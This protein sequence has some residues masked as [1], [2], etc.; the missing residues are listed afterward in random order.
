MD[1]HR[2]G[3]RGSHGRAAG[4]GGEGVGAG[5]GAE[6]GGCGDGRD[7]GRE[8]QAALGQRLVQCGAGV[9]AEKVIAGLQGRLATGVTTG[10]GE[11][12]T[13]A[14]RARQP[15]MTEG[16]EVLEAELGAR[17]GHPDPHRP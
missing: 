7:D 14:D 6:P 3:D 13:P 17:P 8:R 2:A 15:D 1:Q 4:G 10:D 12:H 11:Q 16:E 9:A 5:L